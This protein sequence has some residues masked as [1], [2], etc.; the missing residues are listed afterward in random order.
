[1]RLTRPP[2]C[3][4]MARAASLAYAPSAR[5]LRKLQSLGGIRSL[6]RRSLIRRAQSQAPAYTRYRLRVHTLSRACLLASARLCS[7]YRTALGSHSAARPR[8][9]V[10]R[11]TSYGCVFRAA[12]GGRTRART[13]V[14][15]YLAIARTC[16]TYRSALSHMRSLVHARIRSPTSTLVSRQQLLMLRCCLGLPRQPCPLR[17]GSQALFN[18]H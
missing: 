15:R 10:L 7:C 9:I 1:M 6:L 3:A 11:Y 14:L 13:I 2:N 17:R 12:Q 4:I 16:S 8:T 5:S 18:R